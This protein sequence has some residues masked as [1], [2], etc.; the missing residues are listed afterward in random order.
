MD[1]EKDQV[2]DYFTKVKKP[3]DL[4]TIKG[5]MDRGDYKTDHEFAADVR[6]IFTNCYTYWKEDD[7]MWAACEK[8]QRTFEDKFGQMTKSILR[9]MRDR[10][11]RAERG[12]PAD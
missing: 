5:K 1:P 9:L 6:L 3:M 7:P 8:F 11:E 12:E 10:A 4:M 2:P